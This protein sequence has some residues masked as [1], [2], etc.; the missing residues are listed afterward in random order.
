MAD[1]ALIAAVQKQQAV[2]NK[3]SSEYSNRI[4]IRKQWEEIAIELETDASPHEGDLWLKGPPSGR[5]AGG[6]AQTCNRS[7]SADLRADSQATVPLSHPS[8]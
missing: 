8:H 3:E 1:K 6:G 4:F 7:V 2:Y 5:G